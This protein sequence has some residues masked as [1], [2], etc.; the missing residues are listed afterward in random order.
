MSIKNADN[1]TK[2]WRYDDRGG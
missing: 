2:L 1:M